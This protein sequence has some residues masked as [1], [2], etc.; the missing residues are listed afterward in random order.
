[1]DGT[2]AH[3]L[4]SWPILKA[5]WPGDGGRKVTW[6][7]YLGWVGWAGDGVFDDMI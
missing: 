3:A 7:A 6:L 5:R 2:V 4:F 1:M